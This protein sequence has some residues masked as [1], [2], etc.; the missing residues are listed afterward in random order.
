MLSQATSPTK[1]SIGD[2]QPLEEVAE[3]LKVLE[4]TCRPELGTIKFFQEACLAI[5]SSFQVLGFVVR[6]TYPS[7]FCKALF[8]LI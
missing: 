8:E 2:P 3:D 7:T 4:N 6:S 1:A 5:A